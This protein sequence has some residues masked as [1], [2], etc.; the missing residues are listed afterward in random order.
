MKVSL[1]HYLKVNIKRPTLDSAIV[2][3]ILSSTTL[4]MDPM[5][6]EPPPMPAPSPATVTP[7]TLPAVVAMEDVTSRSPTKFSPR[8][9]PPEKARIWSRKR[10]WATGERFLDVCSF[11]RAETASVARLDLPEKKLKLDKKIV[12][13]KVLRR[14]H[15]LWAERHFHKFKYEVEER[16]Q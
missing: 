9:E 16:K 13:C 2:L 4:A 7:E 10:L 3:M 6:V 12:Q 11:W 14:G 5:A 15:A 1:I 8:N